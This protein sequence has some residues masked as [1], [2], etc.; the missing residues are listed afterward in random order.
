MLRLKALHN[1]TTID[2]AKRKYE[3]FKANFMSFDESVR[4]DSDDNISSVSDRDERHPPV[5]K[6]RLFKHNLL[7]HTR[8]L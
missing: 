8:E 7:R 1:S 5:K 4:Q 3:V 6:N 2:E